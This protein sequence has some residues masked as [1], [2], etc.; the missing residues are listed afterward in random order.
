MP[1]PQPRE[2]VSYLRRAAWH[3]RTGG[4]NG[5]AEFL[6]REKANSR[7]GNAL[8]RTSAAASSNHK[9]GGKTLDFPEHQPTELTPAYG[10]L[11]VAT[12][13]D[14]FSAAAWGHEFTTVPVT[15][16]NWENEIADGI[17][18]LFVESAWAGNSGAW[19]YKLT[20]S[21]APAPELR[22]LV[23]YCKTHG[24]PTL[25]WNKEDPPHFEDFL[26]TAALFDHVFTSDSN[27]IPDYK[28]RLGHDRV[29][30]LAFA[31]Q[32]AI[33]NPIR[34]QHGWH[35]RDVAFAGM[36]FAHKYPERREQMDLL[37]GAAHAASSK[38]EHGLE[39]FSRFL[40]DDPNYQFPAPL[41]TRVVGSLPYS[42]MLTAY[43]AYKVFLNVN[44]VVDSPSMCARRVFEITASGTPVVSTRSEAI[45]RYFSQDQV[46]VVDTEADAQATLRALVRSPE[47]NSR[48]THLAQRAIWAEHTYTHRAEQLLSAA[49]LLPARPATA[50]PTVSAL[51]S[52]N[53]PSQLEHVLRTVSGFHGVEVELNLLTHGH[54]VNAAE[55]R[56][57][58]RDLGLEHLNLLSAEDDVPLG[59]CLNR[60]VAASAGQ[61]L[62]KVDDD[63][64]Y[65][66][67]Y[68]RDL[69][70]ARRFSGADLVGKQAH[71]MHFESSGATMVRNPEREHRWTHFIMGPTLTGSRDV[72]EENPFSALGRGEDTDFLQRVIAAGGRI[73]SADRYNF[74]Q[75]RSASAAHTWDISDR[76]LMGG[77]V[78]SFY[79]RGLEN[80]MI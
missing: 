2:L 6:R 53:R 26:P 79:G 52:T 68:L 28:Q 40:G 29:Q 66:P 44:S 42:K 5:L 4:K 36:Y 15:P 77:G 60:L 8:A 57:F 69:L 16:G 72:F 50:L 59:E 49:H 54:T 74:M 9:N 43:K 30:S 17:D 25:F 64:L 41:D 11:K 51:V 58:A 21:K 33:H 61:V 45:P 22:A 14:D 38:M 7:G 27:K 78:V 73:Y 24:I 34:P 76:E 39:I 23:D 48:T 1:N 13:L 62:T 32:T 12:I 19:R 3:L 47:Y 31:A 20:G 18:M 63:D 10:H 46:P 35:E 56:A 37:L 65:G 67:E 70:Y 80:V 55:V 71:Y 75:V